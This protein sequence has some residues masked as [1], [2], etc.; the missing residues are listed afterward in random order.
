MKSDSFSVSEIVVKNL[1]VP[2]PATLPKNLQAD[3]SLNAKGSLQAATV[4]GPEGFVAKIAPQDDGVSFE[5][6][7]AGFTVGSGSR[8]AMSA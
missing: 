3:V 8:L 6:T 5:V 4:R 2:G 7:A 1:E